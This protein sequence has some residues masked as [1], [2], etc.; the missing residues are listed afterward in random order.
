MTQ[1]HRPSRSGSSSERVLQMEQTQYLASVKAG[2]CP[3]V[4]Q[5]QA[6]DTRAL[7]STFLN[8][9]NYPFCAKSH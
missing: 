2:H 4:G 7:S 3:V 1:P 5:T 6:K 8:F 9:Q